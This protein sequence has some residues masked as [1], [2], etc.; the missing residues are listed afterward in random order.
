M[1]PPWGGWIARMWTRRVGLGFLL[2]MLSWFFATTAYAS[3][4]L[5]VL[6][7]A[8][9]YPAGEVAAGLHDD[10]S[11]A[12]DLKKYAHATWWRLSSSDY[13][14]SGS[15]LLIHGV[16]SRRTVDVLLPGER[17]LRRHSL[18]KDEAYQYSVRA[19]VVSLPDDMRPGQPVWLRIHGKRLGM[20]LFSV[21]SDME[22]RR[23]EISFVYWRATSY[24]LV[25]VS[26]IL[27]LVFWRGTRDD[28][29]LWLSIMM[30]FAMLYI[31]V[32]GGD[33]RAVPFMRQLYGNW[34][35][36]WGLIG[37]G[38]SSA[39]IFVYEILSLPRQQPRFAKWFRYLVIVQILAIFMAFFPS[40][41]VR[42]FLAN[43]VL[44]ISILSIVLVC[45]RGVVRGSHEAVWVWIMIFPIVLVSGVAILHSL[46]LIPMPFYNATQ[47]LLVAAGASALLM[48]MAS[49]GRL[50]RMRKENELA[51]MDGLTGLHRR[52]AIER[53]MNEWISCLGKGQGEFSIAF[54]DVD[55][56]KEINDK[57]GHQVGDHCLR[58][59]SRRLN[60]NI[61][62]KDV[63][64]RYGGDELLLLMP[65]TGL[66]EACC[67]VERLNECATSEPVV[68]EGKTVFITLSIGVAQWQPGESA[69]SLMGRAD[70]ALY[71]SKF[72]GR[73]RITCAESPGIVASSLDAEWQ[74][75]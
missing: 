11:Q 51:H 55:H 1:P 7:L 18:M 65:N 41:F 30:F 26:I 49:G 67:A 60:E 62:D 35:V 8:E 16:Y 66:Q 14:E 19:L 34:R 17:S 52:Q 3:V 40:S 47:A 12:V 59:L 32:R 15:K 29:F 6:A 13:I 23:R 69:C 37:I 44:L 2:A 36:E 25:W 9:D 33:I 54:L 5:E 39:L 24:A 63:L 31:A 22:F 57:F 56:F 64:G 45:G 42:N 71:E 38:M 61:K 74:S 46:Q 27:S 28:G 10:K 75:V 70:G 68:Y 73:N 43:G 48:T 4:K 58:E 72:S 50:I 53:Y 21:E 20:P